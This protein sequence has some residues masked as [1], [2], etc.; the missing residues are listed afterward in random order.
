MRKTDSSKTTTPNQQELI[1]R[2]LAGQLP[3]I[4]IAGH[5]FY[6]DWRFQELRAKD[7]F[8]A[9]PLNLKGMAMNAEGTAYW[10]FYHVPTK[11]EFVVT[12]QLKSLPKDV[13]WLEIPYE[14]KLDPIGVARQYGLEDTAMLHKYPIEPNLIAKVL[15]LKESRLPELIR[16]NRESAKILKRKQSRTHRKGNNI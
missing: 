2:R 4:D 13:V 8:E 5:T 10:C 16:H 6:V 14:L 3:T 12:E 15:P 11:S 7:Y 9:R 1:N